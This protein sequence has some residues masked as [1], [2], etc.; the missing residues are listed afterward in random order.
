MS[1]LAFLIYYQKSQHIKDSRE[2]SKRH[3][4]WSPLA[5]T[6]QLPVQYPSDG[7]RPGGRGY[8]RPRRQSCYQSGSR[9]A[10]LMSHMPT[11]G[12]SSITSGSNSVVLAQGRCA[13][14]LL[15]SLPPSLFSGDFCLPAPSIIQV[16]L[17]SQYEK[18][19]RTLHG[20][21]IT[22]GDHTYSDQITEVSKSGCCPGMGSTATNTHGSH[23]LAVIKSPLRSPIKKVGM[24]HPPQA[25]HTQRTAHPQQE[26][27]WCKAPRD[28][29]AH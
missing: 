23:L 18:T 5:T 2:T 29:A 8:T 4:N 20:W 21:Q 3:S 17:L 7:H 10:A 1:F 25:A 24:D 22:E 14:P 11:A 28:T 9:L 27:C 12:M 26:V 16:F 15:P 6:V 13:R 19:H